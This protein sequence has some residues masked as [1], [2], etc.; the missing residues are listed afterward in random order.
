MRPSSSSTHIALEVLI[1]GNNHQQ[2]CLVFTQFHIVLHQALTYHHKATMMHERL[3]GV[4]HIETI[5]CYVS[6]P[7]SFS[8]SLSLLLCHQFSLA[9]YCQAANSTLTGLKLLYR[10]RYLILLVS[11]S[12]H[13]E[14]ANCDVSQSCYTVSHCITLC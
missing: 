7:C 3:L 11:G 14:L 10:V 13:P 2:C 5:S 12:D 4:D 9:L 6:C 1:E 8:Y